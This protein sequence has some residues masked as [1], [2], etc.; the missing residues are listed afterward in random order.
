VAREEEQVGITRRTTVGLI[1]VAALVAAALGSQMALAQGDGAG[2][3]DDA[4]LERLDELE[5]SLP[6]VVPSDVGIDPEETWGTI[7]GDFGGAAATIDTL[8]DDLR[9]LFRDADD[10]EGVVAEAVSNV[11]RGW[12]DLGE[13]YDALA[14]WEAN[15]LAFPLDTQDDQ[16]VATGADEARGD[17]ERGLRHLLA[18]QERHLAGYVALREEG[19]APDAEAQARLDSRAAEAEEFDEQL[20]PL[21]HRLL[22]L[23]TTMVLMPT[24]RFE[25]DAPGVEARARSFTVT[26]IDREAYLEAQ[27]G[28]S[29]G[30]LPSAEELAAELG[31]TQ[32]RIDCP[33]LPDGAGDPLA[34]AEGAAD[35]DA[36]DAADDADTDDAVA[37]ADADETPDADD[38]DAG[39]D[40]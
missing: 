21:I 8:S 34:P 7:D 17:A 33:E 30:D 16:G 26:C 24:D 2:T 36:D 12:L 37:D 20:R 18:G 27:Q 9:S 13:A 22:S 11:S 23:S 15:D 39:A 35:G 31:L 29:P 38:D 32:E 40:E 28:A 5:V 25:T 6:A 10:A 3:S 14:E 19:A 1:A 4:L